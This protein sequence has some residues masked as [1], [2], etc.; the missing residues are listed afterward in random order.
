MLDPHMS[1]NLKCRLVNLSTICDR[2]ILDGEYD[3]DAGEENFSKQL[4]KSRR[5]YLL[6]PRRNMHSDAVQDHLGPPPTVTLKLQ[7]TQKPLTI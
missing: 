2:Q 1:T 5:F 6:Y 3:R 4:K 7:V